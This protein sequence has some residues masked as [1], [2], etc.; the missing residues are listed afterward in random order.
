MNRLGSDGSVRSDQKSTASM[1]G[2]RHYLLKELEV[3]KVYAVESGISCYIVVSALVI[4][5]GLSPRRAR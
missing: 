1:K 3:S 4:A 5:D 2:L